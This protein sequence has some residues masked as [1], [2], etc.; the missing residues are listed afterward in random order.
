V[1]EFRE[2]IESWDM[3]RAVPLLSDEVVFRSPVVHAPYR[4]PAQVSAILQ[5]VSQVFEDFR[6]TR[7]IGGSEATD[8][9]LVFRARVG[10]REVEGC[11]FIHLDENGSIDEFYVM[12]RPLS[13]LL[14]LAEAMKR[15]FG[16]DGT[17]GDAEA[18]PAAREPTR[19]PG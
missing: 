16:L 9:A 8:H 15:Q 1:K 18:Q 3:D 14:A 7:D 19:R 2:A 10:D 11:D 5:A 6:Y 17:G 13:G 4:G 12:V